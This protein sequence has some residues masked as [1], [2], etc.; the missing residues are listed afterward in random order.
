MRDKSQP[1]IRVCLLMPPCLHEASTREA[2]R[3]MMSLN[4]Y[5]RRGTLAQLQH[6]GVELERDKATA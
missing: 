4:A 2:A 6:D 5:L 1:T 3:Q